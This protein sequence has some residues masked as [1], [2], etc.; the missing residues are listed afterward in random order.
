MRKRLVREGR[1][2]SGDKLSTN[3]KP[4]ADRVQLKYNLPMVYTSKRSFETVVC[5]RARR[6]AQKH[7]L[8]ETETSTAN[9]TSAMIG[10]CWT[11]GVARYPSC[12]E[13]ESP[14]TVYAAM[15]IAPACICCRA[16]LCCTSH[17]AS[18]LP[19]SA[20]RSA[21]S[22]H[23]PLCGGSSFARWRYISSIARQFSKSLMA[24]FPVFFASELCHRTGK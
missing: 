1:D 14:L 4:P 2:R 9:C 3:A 7:F 10:K 21:R 22:S 11:R 15:A 18:R 5:R 16:I 17:L 6:R 24:F 20:H 12:F 19:C 8:A 13:R 23:F